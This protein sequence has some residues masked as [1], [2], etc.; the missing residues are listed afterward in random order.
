MKYQ[1][2]EEKLVLHLECRLNPFPPSI[3]Y[4]WVEGRAV[5]TIKMSSKGQIVVIYPTK[6]KTFGV[7]HLNFMEEKKA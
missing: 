1:L 6:N 7:L 5:K 2:E 3:F 4:Y